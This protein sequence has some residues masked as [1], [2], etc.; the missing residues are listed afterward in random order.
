MTPASPR[1]ALRATALLGIRREPGRLALSVFRLP[2][3]L[4][5]RHLGWLLGHAFLLITHA[6]RNSG[7]RRETVAMT[8]AYD[9]GTHE[10]V[11]CSAWG[12]TTDWIRNIRARPALQIE[13]GR[14]TFT[15][16]QRFL[17]EDESVA[18]VAGFRHRHPRRVRL[19][20]WIFGWGD[21]TS[22]LA[23]K[24]FVR[25]HP[26]VSFRPAHRPTGIA[27]APV[28]VPRT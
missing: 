8:L 6:G 27:Q 5:H 14:E 21:L 7:R 19:I 26:F 22:E 13:I 10:A 23:V 28:F 9:R 16:K 15:P 12:E 1:P 11:V 4:Y 24:D 18:V 25:R 2:L 3:P 17:S 20:A